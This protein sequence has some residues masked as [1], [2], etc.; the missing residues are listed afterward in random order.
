MKRMLWSVLLPLSIVMAGTNESQ[1]VGKWAADSR[2][3]GGLGAMLIFSEDGTVTSTFGAIVDFK[4]E[5]EGNTIKM[6]FKDSPD[7]DTESYEIVDDRLITNPSDPKKR[8]EKT[9]IGVAKRGEPPI[10][11]LWAFKHYTGVMA[12]MQYGSDGMG[13]LCVPMKTSKGRYKLHTEELTMEFEGQPPS[14]RKIQLFGDH[15]LLT[16]TGTEPERKFTRVAR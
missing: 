8:E 10:A 9:R 4:Y 14:S 12:T 5:V 2:T 3:K 13:Q 16:A 15:L 11:G 7:Q 6:T 1:I